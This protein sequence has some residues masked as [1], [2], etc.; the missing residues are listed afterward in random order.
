MPKFEYRKSH[1]LIQS[2]GDNGRFT[3]DLF[4]QHVISGSNTAFGT[5]TTGTCLRPG[6]YTTKAGSACTITLPDPADCPG[7]IITVLGESDEAHTVTM[8]QP[9]GAGR[10][11]IPDTEWNGKA[12]IV[13]TEA[14]AVGSAVGE[15]I[16]LLSDGVGWIVIGC[17]GQWNVA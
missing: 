13:A 16:Q 9:G 14:T 11:S 5:A 1:G 6:S 12:S 7:G 8:A 4:P 10:I 2:S 3:T 17:Q 15:A